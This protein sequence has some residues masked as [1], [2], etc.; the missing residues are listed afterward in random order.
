MRQCSKC[1]KYDF[2]I[3]KFNSRTVWPNLWTDNANVWVPLDIDE[4][5]T[6]L[7]QSRIFSGAIWREFNAA[8]FT[9]SSPN[10]TVFVWLFKIDH[11]FNFY[12][13]NNGIV[14]VESFQFTII[15]KQMNG[16]FLSFDQIQI[17]NCWL[18]MEKRNF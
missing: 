5:H 6:Q 4:L 16:L 12:L 18:I 3:L 8:K 2:W 7:Q 15:A 14:E 1:E 10:S 11:I 9:T 13:R 17:I